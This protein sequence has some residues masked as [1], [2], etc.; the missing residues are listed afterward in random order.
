MWGIPQGCFGNCVL[1]WERLLGMARGLVF[2]MEFLC[3][4]IV[5]DGRFKLRVTCLNR[6]FDMPMYFVGE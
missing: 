3:K 4:P 6:D 5:Y 1:T 2:G